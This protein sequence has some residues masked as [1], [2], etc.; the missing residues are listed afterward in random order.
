MTK[1][2]YG[3]RDREWV[4]AFT[5]PDGE[6]GITQCDTMEQAMELLQKCS[7]PVGIMTTAFYN[8]RVNEEYVLCE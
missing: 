8:H 3:Y 6:R 7:N 4:V 1:L 5:T 2:D